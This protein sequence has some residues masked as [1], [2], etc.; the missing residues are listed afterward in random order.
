MSAMS[1]AHTSES[2]MAPPVVSEV[3]SET[4][5]TFE[6][7]D[8]EGARSRIERMCE[9]RLEDNLSICGRGLRVCRKGCEIDGESAVGGST[10]DDK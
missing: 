7:G 8:S 4:L 9:V 6:L 5:K 10:L 2:V 1:V 3:K